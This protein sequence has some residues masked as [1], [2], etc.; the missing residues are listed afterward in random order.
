MEFHSLG[1]WGFQIHQWEESMMME[2]GSCCFIRERPVGLLPIKLSS[3]LVWRV[4]RVTTSC[5]EWSAVK[6]LYQK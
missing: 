1:V 2:D 3:G 4:S 5:E 6:Y